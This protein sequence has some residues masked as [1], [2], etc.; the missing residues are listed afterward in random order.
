MPAI[1]TG[2]VLVTG[3]NGYV[4]AWAIKQLLNQGFSVRGTVRSAHKGHHLKTMFNAF[5]T[6]LEFIVVDDFTKVRP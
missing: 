1:T 5:S 2:K 4:A 6:R 3:A